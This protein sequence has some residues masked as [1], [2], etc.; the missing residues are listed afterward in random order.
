MIKQD[1]II[2]SSE[3]TVEFG[4]GD[5]FLA[6]KRHPDGGKVSI[7]IREMEEQEKIG[8]RVND[9][10]FNMDSVPI[11]MDFNNVNSLYAFRDIVNK[12]IEL[13]EEKPDENGNL[14]IV[15][16]NNVFV[17]MDKKFEVGKYIEALDKVEKATV[18]V[19]NQL[20]VPV[21][22][23]NELLCH[24]YRNKNMKEIS[25][26]ARNGIN[27]A[28]MFGLN[29]FNFASPEVTIKVNYSKTLDVPNITINDKNGSSFVAPTTDSIVSFMD[30]ISAVF[31]PTFYLVCG[32]ESCEVDKTIKDIIDKTKDKDYSCYVK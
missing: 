9:P 16:T 26:Y 23:D 6:T 13:F 28:G 18:P 32:E 19:V 3:V 21:D 25:V 31:R 27:V 2:E 29:F 20:I 4:S 10:K 24:I 8:E 5:I 17:N 1:I 22:D 12:A 15:K 14:F 30:H 11:I 7:L